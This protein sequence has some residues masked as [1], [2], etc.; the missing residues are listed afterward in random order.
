[1]T[2]TMT[3]MTK[4][5][6]SRRRRRWSPVPRV[7]CLLVF[8]CHSLVPGV[9]VAALEEKDNVPLP[10][11]HWDDL[12]AQ[13]VVGNNGLTVQ[14]NLE[15]DE[16]QQIG[17]CHLAGYLAFSRASDT[18]CNVQQARKIYRELAAMYLAM[19][20]FNTGS[21]FVKREKEE[22]ARATSHCLQHSVYIQYSPIL[23]ISCT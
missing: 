3:S 12:R 1:M 2:T 13:A 22:S 8:L 21:E 10:M 19:Y 6:T 17:Y 23:L 20:H 5:V 18:A 16:A 14:G 7:A 9:V 4:M 11:G 15:W